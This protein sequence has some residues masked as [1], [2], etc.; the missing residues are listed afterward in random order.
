MEGK[1]K[2]K[3]LLSTDFKQVFSKIIDLLQM[4]LWFFYFTFTF[5]EGIWM[6][7]LHV[8]N[9][10]VM[11][12][13]RMLVWV[14]CPELLSSRAPLPLWPPGESVSCLLWLLQTQTSLICRIPSHLLAYGW[15]HLHGDVYLSLQLFW[16]LSCGCMGDTGV[17]PTS[18]HEVSPAS[19]SKTWEVPS[20]QSCLG[21]SS[22][23]PW[24]HFPSGICWVP[25]AGLSFQAKGSP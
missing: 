5:F 2:I 18:C 9:T 13:R 16:V 4:C 15:H 21:C 8:F 3:Y 24:L 22:S 25:L 7:I 11:Q 17:A 23:N 6:C 14:M 19:F 20:P 12:S 1:G 10:W